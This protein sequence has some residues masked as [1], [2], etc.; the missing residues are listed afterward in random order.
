ML[1]TLVSAIVCLSAFGGALAQIHQLPHQRQGW[2][3]P[4]F[5]KVDF[6]GIEAEIR[7]RMPG[8]DPAQLTLL[9]R[10]NLQYLFFNRLNRSRF[11]ALPSPQ[12]VA[13]RV[14]MLLRLNREISRSIG[15]GKTFLQPTAPRPKI[16]Q[17]RQLIRE[18]E[19]TTKRLRQQFGE[20]FLEPVDSSFSF[21]MPISKKDFRF[22]HF[23][24]QADRINQ[25]LTQEMDG[26]FLAE[27]PGSI[28]FS[29]YQKVTITVLTESLLRL[30]KLSRKVLH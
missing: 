27:S 16:S 22:L 14:S 13:E 7:V 9:A 26:Y 5:S 23:V 1:R 21:S 25:H 3:G 11:L 19:G 8:E 4:D 18:I 12:D 17:Q 29:D 6:S 24:H 30:C 15:N 2:S 20:F 28:H 10:R